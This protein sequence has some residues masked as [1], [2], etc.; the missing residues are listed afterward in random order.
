MMI[1]FLSTGSFGD[2]S[3]LSVVLAIRKNSSS[4]LWQKFNALL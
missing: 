2:I 1:I 4:K 3:G